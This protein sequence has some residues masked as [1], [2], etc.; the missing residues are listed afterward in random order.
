[1]DVYKCVTMC[2]RTVFQDLH[3]FCESVLTCVIMY[4]S[5]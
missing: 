5:V 3:E 4:V 2:V 1:M